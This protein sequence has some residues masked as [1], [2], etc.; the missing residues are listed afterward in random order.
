[1]TTEAKRT[2]H[3]AVLDV[4]AA[5]GAV[6]KGSMQQGF[7]FRGIDAVL[8]SVAPAM[9]DHG[10]TIHPTKVE[11]RRG[12]QQ[13]SGGKSGS[14]ID[15]IVDYA[16]TGPDGS[17]FTAQVAAE[18]SDVGDK[19]TA[20]AMSVA[21]RT[22][23]IQ[24]FAIPTEESG[25]DWAGLFETATSRG[26]DALLALRHQGKAAGAPEGMFKAIED[27]LAALPLEGKIQ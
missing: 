26:K 23:L 9:R 2:V 14:C 10:L 19:A 5:I 8:N 11:H 24:T 16:F 18:A 12:V 6:G 1:M 13:F 3:Q 15:V 27:A 7:A 21:L 20:K 4:M 25:P 22:C 17:S